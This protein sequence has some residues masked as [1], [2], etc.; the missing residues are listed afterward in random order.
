[1][2]GF[3]IDTAAPLPSPQAVTYSLEKN[4]ARTPNAKKKSSRPGT[5]QAGALYLG[6]A[7]ELGDVLKV[8]LLDLR[9]QLRPR[10][11]L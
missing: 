3:G 10:E 5:E 2:Y 9:A 1:M 8:K 11:L 7:V 4:K 6:A